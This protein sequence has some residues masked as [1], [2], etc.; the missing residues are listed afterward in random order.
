VGPQSS[1]THRRSV[2]RGPRRRHLLDEKWMRP[3]VVPRLNTRIVSQI[4][5]L[6]SDRTHGVASSRS[7]PMR[8]GEL[9]ALT[10]GDVDLVGGIVHVRRAYTGGHLGLPKGRERRSVDLTADVVQLLGRGWASSTGPATTRSCSPRRPPRLPSTT[11]SA[12][13]TSS[14]L[15][16]LRRVSPA[17]GQP[18][19]NGVYGHVE[20]AAA[21]EQI[22]RRRVRGVSGTRLVLA[23]CGEHLRRCER[24]WKQGLSFRGAEI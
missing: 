11:R 5:P 14:T 19:R 18:A 24:P 6:W 12:G 13:R 17:S 4:R 15:R 20:R 16:W 8:I 23:P 1:F 21:K 10:W 7:R 22:A 9:A 3:V 2:P